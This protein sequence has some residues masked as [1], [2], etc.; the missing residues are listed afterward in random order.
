[1]PL[2]LSAFRVFKLT[3]LPLGVGAALLV[4]GTALADG[5]AVPLSAMGGIAA[6]FVIT[7]AGHLRAADALSASALRRAASSETFRA[8]PCRC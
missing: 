6:T 3:A 1:M 4:A 5:P 8:A 2:E 7:A